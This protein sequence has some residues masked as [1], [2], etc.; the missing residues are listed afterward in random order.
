[1][2]QTFDRTRDVKILSEMLISH[3]DWKVQ[4]RTAARRGERLDVDAVGQIEGC[5][6]GRWIAEKGHGASGFDEL[7]AAHNDFHKEAALVATMCNTGDHHMA[8]AMLAS[9]TPFA[10]ATAAIRTALLRLGR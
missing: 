9:G 5:A 10:R 4:L 7:E 2:P 8:E 6:M 3:A 1:M